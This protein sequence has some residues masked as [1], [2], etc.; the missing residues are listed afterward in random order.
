MKKNGSGR[1]I[2]I[3][4]HE[5]KE[6]GREREILETVAEHAKG[7]GRLV[8][9][10]VATEL[11]EQMAA[12]YRKVFGELGVH[13]IDALDIRSREDAK[14]E[15]AVEK[16][17]GA[18]VIFFTGGDQLRITSQIGDSPVYQCLQEMYQ[19]HGTTVAGTSAG[20]AAMPHTMLIAGPG[21]KSNE[22]SALGM[23]PGLGLVDGVVIDSHF[24]ERG[25]FGRLIGAVAQNPKNLGLG[26]DEDTAVVV[27]RDEFE[28]IGSGAVY[29][30]DGTEMSFSSLSESQ[31]EGVLSVFNAKVH[32]LARGDRFD[33]VARRPVISE[34]AL[35]QS[36]LKGSTAA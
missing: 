35:R 12:E 21:D 25:R 18:R 34:E 33:M 17:A 9:V 29:V 4:G 32:V 30:L 16:I 31:P 36:G 2:I 14:Q 3:G 1:L 19:K 8:I 26:I 11:P 23:A 13:H 10:T 28:V 7:R 24:A 15:E 6:A 5:Q 20:A 27:T 22:I